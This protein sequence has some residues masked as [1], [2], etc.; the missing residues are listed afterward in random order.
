VTGSP[1]AIAGVLR[2]LADAGA[3]EAILVVDPITERSVR[4]LGAVVAQIS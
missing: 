2:E 4:A 3:D 1:D